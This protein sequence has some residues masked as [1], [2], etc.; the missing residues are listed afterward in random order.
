MH[1]EQKGAKKVLVG[2]GKGEGQNVH[3][4]GHG[5]VAG[6]EGVNSTSDFARKSASLAICLSGYYVK[7]ELLRN[8]AKVGKPHF[9]FVFPEEELF[10]AF[11]GPLVCMFRG[12]I[13][14]VFW[15]PSCFS[16]RAFRF[17][18]GARRGMRRARR[19]R[20]DRSEKR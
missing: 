4:S 18:N 13:R 16:G 5:L 2:E 20:E 10:G 9:R 14:F 8:T 15:G 12:K 17:G 11:S 19:V 3:P 1:C 6:F 7:F